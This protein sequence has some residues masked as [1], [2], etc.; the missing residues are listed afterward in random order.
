MVMPLNAKRNSANKKVLYM[1][2]MH[3]AVSHSIL[4]WTN[5]SLYM[6]F[7]ITSHKYKKKDVST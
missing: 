7:C 5:Y 6:D 1:L 3:T 2:Y 4:S